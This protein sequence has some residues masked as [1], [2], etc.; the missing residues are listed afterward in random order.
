MGCRFTLDFVGRRGGNSPP[1]SN[2][3]VRTLHGW[4]SALALILLSAAPLNL[5]LRD[6]VG[7]ERKHAASA[8]AAVSSPIV[9]C[10]FPVRGG[11]EESSPGSAGML[12]QRD[13]EGARLLWVEPSGSARVLVPGFHSAADPDVSFD[14]KRILFAG[15]RTAADRW[16]IYEWTIATGQLRQVIR[17]AGDCRS[18]S[19][20]G[21]MYTMAEELAWLQITFVQTDAGVTNEYGGGPASSIWSCK[22]DGSYVQRLTY[23]L[24]SDFD[25]AILPDGRLVFA[26]WRRAGFDHGLAG[27][28]ALMGVNT[29]GIDLATF[30]GDVGKRVQ[31]SPCATAS[32]LVVFVEA[33]TLPRDG[34]GTLACV[35]L[36]RPLH[37]YRPITAESDGLF[38]SPSALPDGRI[39]VSRR[40]ADGSSPHAV[41]CLDP[42]TKRLEPVFA[43]PGFHCVQAQAVVP[44]PEPDGRSSA[45]TLEVPLGKFYCLDVSKTEFKDPTWFPRGTAKKVRVLEGIPCR[46]AEDDMNPGGRSAPGVPQLAARRILG[47]APVAGDG[48]FNVEVPANTPIQ[49]QLLDE[50]GMA[51]RSCGWIWTRNHESQGCIGCHEDP[52]LTPANLLVDALAVPTVSAAPPP[53]KR[54]TIDFRRDVMPIVERKCAGC[55]GAGGSPPR[56]DGTGAGDAARA[57]AVY[58]TLLAHDEAGSDRSPRWKY[59]EPGK[60]RTS[61]LAWH[62]EGVNTSR[63]WDGPAASRAV[64]GIPPGNTEPLSAEEKSML[65]GWI[66]LGARWEGMAAQASK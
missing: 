16:A 49:L 61:P 34:A 30:C 47:E 38:H 39:L 56:L 44:R 17:T 57:K 11:L 46:A 7:G 41:W 36:R 14:G 51:L 12:P 22:L 15:K 64:K 55:H 58:E 65:I 25:P 1:E 8:R 5:V 40:P 33:D 66:D 45:L 62:V 32:G 52:E 20:Q 37:T 26:A 23:N 10:E 29:D 43:D 28:V 35:S 4:G 42:A 3:K 21:F 2:G 31:H 59:V 50:R 27:R 9:V 53:E 48:S 54:P 13:D 6:A 19:Y 60:A 24:S 18:P 63:P